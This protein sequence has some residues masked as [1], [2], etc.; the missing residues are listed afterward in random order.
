[1]R[2]GLHGPVDILFVV[3]RTHDYETRPWGSFANRDQR[4]NAIH[5]W[6]PKVKKRNIR[7]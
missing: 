3:K 6:H 4:F 2:S 1:V 7:P 5:N